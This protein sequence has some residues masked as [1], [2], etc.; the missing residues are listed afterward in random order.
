MVGDD[1][2]GFANRNNKETKDSQKEKMIVGIGIS[3]LVILFVVAIVISMNS[4][5]DFVKMIG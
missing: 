3:V 1:K 4:I 2:S 5:G